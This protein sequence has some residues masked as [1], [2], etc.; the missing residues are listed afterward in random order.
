MAVKLLVVD[1][2]DT[3]RNGIANYIRLHCDRVDKIYTACNGQ[4]AIDMIIA[5]QPQIMLLD[6]QMPVKDGMEVLREA[7][8]AKIMPVTIILSGYDEFKYAQQALRFGVK[9]YVLK[10]CRSTEILKL[11]N[12]SIDEIIGEE[13]HETGE[14]QSDNY[15]VNRAIEY[16]NEHYNENITLSSVA[17]K[18]DISS[19]YLSALFS[20]HM[21]CGFIDYLNQLRIDHACTYLKQNRLKVYEI[22]FK[23]GYKDEKYF[24]KVFKKVTGISPAQ[25]KKENG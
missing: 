21:D 16:M 2:E 7:E 9:E 5:H 15:L 11:V 8:N 1:D 6:I 25:Y 13:K 18:I 19:G 22:A 4:E 10:P 24:S 12:K 3:I 14:T 23:V 20:G 17:E